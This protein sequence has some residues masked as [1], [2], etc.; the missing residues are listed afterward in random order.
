MSVPDLLYSDI[1]EGCGMNTKG[2]HSQVHRQLRKCS[3][4][5]NMKREREIGR[6]LSVLNKEG[7]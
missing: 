4:L 3:P 5:Q 7:I 2:E 6:E 1:I